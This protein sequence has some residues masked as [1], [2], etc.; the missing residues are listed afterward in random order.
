MS[1]NNNNKKQKRAFSKTLLIQESALIWIMTLVF[2]Y[3]AYLSIINGYM[4]SLPFLT[5]MVS[6]PWAAYG[7]SQALYYRKS[8]A[9]NTQGGLTYEKMMLENQYSNSTSD[10]VTPDNVQ[11]IIDSVSENVNKTIKD[12]VG[13]TTINQNTT[14]Y[15]NNDLPQ[16]EDS[17][18]D[19]DCDFE[20]SLKIENGATV[21]K[22]YT[23][24]DSDV[25]T[26][27]NIDPFG[28]I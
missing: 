27:Q 7:V 2:L 24:E 8:Q 9:E 4:G 15:S 20:S 13:T 25:T 18:S 17:I 28:P 26:K 3:L 16:T 5:A 11:S 12:T 19:T 6:L 23:N 22:E 14:T 10:T 1:E 21:A